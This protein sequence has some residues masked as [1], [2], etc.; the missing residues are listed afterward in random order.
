MTILSNSQTTK[1][2]VSV[3]PP[4]AL[5]GALKRIRLSLG[6]NPSNAVIDRA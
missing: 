5:Q 3:Y 4:R 2:R 6:R 1:R